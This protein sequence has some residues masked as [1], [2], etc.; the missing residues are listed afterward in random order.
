[1]QFRRPLVAVLTTVVIGSAALSRQ[2]LT[3]VEPDPSIAMNAR[4]PVPAQV[5]SVLRRAC[6]DCHSS[7]THWP[8]YAQLPIASHVIE[9]DVSDAR[10]QLDWSQWAVYNAF[11]RAGMLDKTCEL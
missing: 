4:A 3:L 7:E 6:Y 2:P 1:M 11:D 9:R 5:M 8:W 10:G